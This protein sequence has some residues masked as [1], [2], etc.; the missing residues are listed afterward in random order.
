MKDTILTLLSVLALLLVLPVSVLW[1]RDRIFRSSGEKTR[2]QVEARLHA[3]RE[4][5]LHPQQA[6]V[7]A[8][9]GALLPQSLIVLYADQELLR[10]EKFEICPPGKDSKKSSE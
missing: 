8:Q 1:L 4:R 3:Y 9:L 6:H 2:E 10:S 5:L 7:E